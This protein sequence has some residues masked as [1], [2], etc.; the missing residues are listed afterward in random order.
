RGN[1]GVRLAQNL[2]MNAAKADGVILESPNA[3]TPGEGSVAEASARDWELIK[4]GKYP[5][6]AEARQ[7]LYD[8]R[9]AP[10]DTDIGD[11]E[12]LIVGLRYVFGDSSNHPDGCVIHTPPCPPGWAPIDSYLLAFLDTSNDPQVLRAD[13][14]NQITHATDA[15]VSSP[16]VR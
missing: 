7:V 15:W 9:E 16:E 5:D 11:R 10:A 2:R 14:L 6:L 8:H 3:F 12:S 4:S 1:G 13:L